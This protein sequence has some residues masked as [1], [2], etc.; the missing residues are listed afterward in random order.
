LSVIKK[1]HQAA[2]K[3]LSDY[4]SRVSKGQEKLDEEHKKSLE[5]TRQT[6]KEALDDAQAAYDN[7]FLA[8]E[9]RLSDQ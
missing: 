3:A 1:N 7:Y 4:D 2:R 5:E 9:N 8:I 6:Q